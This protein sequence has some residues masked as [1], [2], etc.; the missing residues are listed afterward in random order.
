LAVVV[1]EILFSCR[2]IFFKEYYHIDSGVQDSC[3]HVG[4]FSKEE[5]KIKWVVADDL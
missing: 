3:N 1:L 4:K 2:F 5:N